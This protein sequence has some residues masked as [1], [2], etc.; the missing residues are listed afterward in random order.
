MCSEL[1]KEEKKWLTSGIIKKLPNSL[2]KM[3]MNRTSINKKM[4]MKTS[5]KKRGEMSSEKEIDKLNR[6]MELKI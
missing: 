1:I 5:E 6:E 3:T 2:L 4:M